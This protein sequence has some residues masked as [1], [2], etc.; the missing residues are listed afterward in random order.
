[1]RKIG[2]NFRKG[3]G[4]ALIPNVNNSLGFV[5]FKLNSRDYRVAKGLIQDELQAQVLG[6]KNTIRNW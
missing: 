3:D 5:L 6:S 4:L 1:M 2:E